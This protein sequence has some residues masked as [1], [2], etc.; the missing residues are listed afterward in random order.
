MPDDTVPAEVLARWLGVSERLVRELA[1]KGIVV[2]AGRNA[3]KLE[4]SVRS[5][6]EDQRRTIA[7]K[8]GASIAAQAAKER[9]R[10]AAAMA[11]KAELQNAAA[12][13]ALLDAG[14]VEREWTAT[15]AGVR[16]RMLAVPSRAAQRL[17]HLGAHDVSEIDREVRDALAEAARSGE[18]PTSK[19]AAQGQRF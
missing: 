17:P 9:S 6:V 8:G 16:A 13:G 18:P 14:D 10:L 11:D 7:G 12:R 4:E 5:V 15:F 2:K 19:N 1:R 3:F